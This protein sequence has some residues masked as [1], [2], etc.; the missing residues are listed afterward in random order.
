ML[1][2]LMKIHQKMVQPISSRVIKPEIQ[3]KMKAAMIASPT[4]QS[5]MV[6]S[7]AS[8]RR[9]GSFVVTLR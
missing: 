4:G 1:V 9:L 5:R 3:Y 2:K 6:S 8:K 7:V